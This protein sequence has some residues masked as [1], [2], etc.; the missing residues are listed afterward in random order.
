M[1]DVF[2]TA[3][4]TA[5]SGNT[6]RLRSLPTT[7]ARVIEMIP[8]GEIVEVI[9]DTNDEWCYISDSGVTGYMM[10]KFL[11]RIEEEK[12]EEKTGEI[13]VDAEVLE[14]LIECLS[15]AITM[16][17]EMLDKIHVG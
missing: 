10:K 9:E 2:Y 15:A 11:E 8:V 7:G 17:E 4:V 5:Q 12:Q 6:V 3:K 14:E 16:V 13:S 1:A